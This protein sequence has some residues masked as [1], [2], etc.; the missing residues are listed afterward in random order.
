[1]DFP[2][3]SPDT[4]SPEYLHTSPLIFSLFVH[5]PQQSQRILPGTGAQSDL[6]CAFIYAA[7]GHDGSLAVQRA[8]VNPA[9]KEIFKTKLTF[10]S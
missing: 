1:M 4:Y 7:D 2:F 9:A 10:R 6:F 8:V 3:K 5:D